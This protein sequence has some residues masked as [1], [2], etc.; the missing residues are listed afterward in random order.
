[1][2]VKKYG[3]ILTIID[4]E[5]L[6]KISIDDVPVPIDIP[7][8]YIVNF[9]K[10]DISYR[11]E[12]ELYEDEPLFKELAELKYEWDNA[13]EN[14]VGHVLDLFEEEVEYTEEELE[15]AVAYVFPMFGVERKDMCDTNDMVENKE[16]CTSCQE[17]GRQI[18]PYILKRQKKLERWANIKKVFYLPRLETIFVTVPM[19]EYLLENGVSSEYFI[20]AYGG[21][22]KRT[23][24]GYQIVSS[25]QLPQGAYIEP[26][27]EYSETCSFCGRHR[28]KC[29]IKGTEAYYF[30]NIFL[31]ESK[32]TEWKEINASYESYSE[33]PVL[34]VSRR[35]KELLEKAD[36]N[37]KMLPVFKKGSIKSWIGE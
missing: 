21:V 27:W 23:L 17:Y 31:D 15:H 25:H 37:L 6:D 24:L 20:P 28:I 33:N 36:P 16:W 22:R 13:P 1:M 26:L 32:I 34:I 5:V 14:G 7:A 8:Q 10:R 2:R 29:V 12:L 4:D 35:V 3:G 18:S 30:H 11:Y 19:Y 9:Y